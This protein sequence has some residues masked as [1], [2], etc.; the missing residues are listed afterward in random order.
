MK[1]RQEHI[2][3]IKCLIDKYHNKVP[4]ND[5]PINNYIPTDSWFSI[6]ESNKFHF[7]N[8]LNFNKQIYKNK[9]IKCKKII[10]QPTS[11]Q[12]KVLLDWINSVRLMYNETLRYIKY[13]YKENLKTVLSFISLR[14][15]LR[16]KKLNLIKIYN[17]PTHILDSGIKL[18][19]ISYKSALSNYKNGNIKFFNIRYLKWH[20][21]THIMDIEQQYLSK[22]T[23]CTKKLG[24]KL[25][26]KS[27]IQ[28]NNIK[29]DCKLHYNKLNNTF[30]LLVPIE[31]ERL[32]RNKND[33]YISIDPGVRTFL[34]G[35]CNDKHFEI[36]KNGYSTIKCI[37]KRIDKTD[38]KKKK[39]RLRLKLKNKVTD[40]HWKSIN[41][42]IK[43]NKNTIVI[44]NWSTKNCISKKG[45]LN[46]MLKRVC[47]SLRYYEFLQKLIYKS[48]YNDITL[49]IQ[50][51]AYTSKM[52]SECGKI[53]NTL[54]SSKV[55]NCSKCKL[56]Y[57]R[58]MNACRNILMKSLN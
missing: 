46:R 44:G 35:M 1:N 39:N 17:T 13:R 27:K 52:C 14:K 16:N 2:N 42:L 24:K 19:S 8:N 32:N 41:Y 34:T 30:T 49:K 53:N 4:L 21:N 7:N 5:I 31:K 6:N 51:E 58:D 20:K 3:K 29:K 50:D 15:E 47:S 37:L 9:I 11:K 38:S 28:Y 55:F 25:L 36:C 43:Q 12:Q 18:A 26:N 10:L 57:D 54:G 40:L 45:S 56:C 33:E 22:N 23:I 48:N